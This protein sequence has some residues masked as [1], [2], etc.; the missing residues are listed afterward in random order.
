MGPLLVGEDP[1]ATCLIQISVL[2][3]F[4]IHHNHLIMSLSTDGDPEKARYHDWLLRIQ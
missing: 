1:A 2:S 3:A 4:S